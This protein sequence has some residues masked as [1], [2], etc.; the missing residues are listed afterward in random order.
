MLGLEVGGVAMNTVAEDP[1]LR[2]RIF[3]LARRAKY[4]PVFSMALRCEASA[5]TEGPLSCGQLKPSRENR[6][7]STTKKL[8]QL[9][10]LLTSAG[11][12]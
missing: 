11:P 12:K 5:A 10:F 4:F 6:L 7:A 2:K 1:A 9:I 8:G 3:S